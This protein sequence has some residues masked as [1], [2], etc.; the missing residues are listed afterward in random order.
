[1]ITKLDASWQTWIKS[2]IDRGCNKE[3]LFKIMLDNQ[4][5]SN[6]IQTSLG[7]KELSQYLKKLI[8]DE[9]PS[10]QLFNISED[11]FKQATKVPNDKARAY[12][13]HEF[14][15]KEECNQ[16]IE[17]IRKTFG[18]LLLQLLMNMISISVLVKLV[19]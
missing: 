13:Q 17:L 8:N 19:I 4:F 1:M 3:E 11:R 14:L 15:S 18:H 5:D 10:S 12:I 6:T 16:V 2:N 9:T 7:L